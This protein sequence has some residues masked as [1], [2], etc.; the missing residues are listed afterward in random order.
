M[1][2]GYGGCSLVGKAPP[3][4]GGDRGFESRHPPKMR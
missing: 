4:G 3:C 2:K 1:N